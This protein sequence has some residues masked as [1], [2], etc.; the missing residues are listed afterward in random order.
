[1][2]HERALI[3]RGKLP[4]L[5]PGGPEIPRGLLV[6]TPDGFSFEY[7]VDD[8][9]LLAVR[10]GAF[11]RRLDW[12]GR[13]GDALEPLGKVVFRV[14]TS[15]P[16][17][18]FFVE[19]G[20]GRGAPYRC[21]LRSTRVEREAVTLTYD[22]VR[23]SD[24]QRRVATV[25]ES[26]RAQATPFGIGIV[27]RFRVDARHEPRVIEAFVNPL[28]TPAAPPETKIRIA[29]FGA[30]PDATGLHRFYTQ[31]LSAPDPSGFETVTMACHPSSEA[32]DA[33]KQ[34]V[35]RVSSDDRLPYVIMLYPAPGDPASFTLTTF[36]TQE[37]DAAKL[38]EA[39]SK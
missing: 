9:R 12:I 2:V 8:L 18:P 21:R 4:A 13:G 27:R 7:R 30:R 31:F 5:D 28:R 1:V 11:V 3:A 19:P 39:F 32:D 38:Y 35:A 26:V 17:A 10:Q 29:G 23:P 20:A 15:E 36:A 6:G 22:L 25:E 33:R 24:P 14:R 37:S 34:G 16:I